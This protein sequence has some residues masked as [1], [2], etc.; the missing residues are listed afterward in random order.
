MSDMSDRGMIHIKVSRQATPDRK[1]RLSLFFLMRLYTY[2]KILRLVNSAVC[3][4][5]NNMMKM[6]IVCFKTAQFSFGRENSIGGK[7][8]KIDIDTKNTIRKGQQ[9]LAQKI[10]LTDFFC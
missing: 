10:N 2:A 6:F 5:I 1:E 9:D 8:A 7:N 3:F 4:K